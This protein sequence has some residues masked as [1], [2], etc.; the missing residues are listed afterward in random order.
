MPLIALTATA[1]TST[2]LRIM[3]SLEMKKPSL[4]IESPDR[5]NIS[6]AVKVVTPDPSKTF[7]SMLKDRKEQKDNYPRTIIYCQTIKVTTF[8]YGF[9]QS[10]LGSD[11]YVDY[12]VDPKK[13]IV[14]MFH[15]RI[16]TLNR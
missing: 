5:Q 7:H 4:F 2:R 12:S 14:E 6:Y 13:R 3:W 16:D 9:F 1:T 11:M 15:S 10:E 8:L